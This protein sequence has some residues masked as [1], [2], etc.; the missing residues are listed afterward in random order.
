MRNNSHCNGKRELPLIIT[1]N[2]LWN[3]LL[4]ARAHFFSRTRTP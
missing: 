4:S 3:R 1:Y 2:T